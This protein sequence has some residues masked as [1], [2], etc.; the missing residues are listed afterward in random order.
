MT[1]KFPI[2]SL[3]NSIFFLYFFEYKL[4]KKSTFSTLILIINKLMN[5]FRHKNDIKND[6]FGHNLPKYQRY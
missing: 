2:L 1:Q 5:F 4:K 6:E 3:Y